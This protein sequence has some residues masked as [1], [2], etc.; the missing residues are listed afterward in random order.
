MGDV[1][2]AAL[3][4]ADVKTGGSLGGT[5]EI[6]VEVPLPPHAAGGGREEQ[7]A[8]VGVELDLRFQHPSEGRG[9]GNDAAR[10][11]LALM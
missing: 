6:A 3:V 8:L 2:V 5:P 1:A 9:N 7:L 4:G 10:V 11:G